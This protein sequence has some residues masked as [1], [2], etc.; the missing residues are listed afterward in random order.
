MLQYILKSVPAGH[1]SKL[2]QVPEHTPN[3]FKTF[4]MRFLNIFRLAIL[5]AH[6]Y[7]RDL[8]YWSPLRSGCTTLRVP[9]STGACDVHGAPVFFCACRGT[10]KLRLWAGTWYTNDRVYP[11]PG[12][13]TWCTYTEIESGLIPTRG[14]GPGGP[15]GPGPLPDNGIRAGSRHEP[16]S[17]TSLTGS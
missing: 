11:G 9:E 3:I 10:Q 8:K 14:P 17:E 13:T 5:A 7:R 4:L 6:V 1:L 15:S 2:C 12:P 16:M